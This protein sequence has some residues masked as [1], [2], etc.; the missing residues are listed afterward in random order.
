MCLSESEETVGAGWV[1]QESETDGVIDKKAV[2]CGISACLPCLK[3][4]FEVLLED[5]SCVEND[6]DIFLAKMMP[7]HVYTRR[8]KF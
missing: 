4:Y 8:N 2:G 7:Q 5:A 3:T 1:H 6:N